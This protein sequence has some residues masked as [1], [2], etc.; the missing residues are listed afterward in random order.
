[1]RMGQEHEDGEVAAVD[2][3][4][5]STAPPVPT[6]YNKRDS[7]QAWKAGRQV[8]DARL[9]PA[10]GTF[11]VHCNLYASAAHCDSA[12]A[13]QAL[14]SEVAHNA[15]SVQPRRASSV[16]PSMQSQTMMPPSSAH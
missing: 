10:D 12:P 14:A 9:T 3:C 6:A 8:I 11:V 5:R 15:A 13:H 1:M 4:Q 2:C 7:W 16:C